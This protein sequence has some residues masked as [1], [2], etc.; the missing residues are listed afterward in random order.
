MK[1][2]LPTTDSQRK[3][4]PPP[5]HIVQSI[6]E[7]S[8]LVLSSSWPQ[9]RLHVFDSPDEKKEDFTQTV[10]ANVT[11]SPSENY[12][13]TYLKTKKETGKIVLYSVKLS[14]DDQPE[15]THQDGFDID[16]DLPPE[17]RGDNSLTVSDEGV[18]AL[19]R[20]VSTGMYAYNDF[21]V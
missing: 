1:R 3:D 15:V 12:V 19:V 17:M 14:E 7:P 5:H 6:T 8:A 13:V 20:V 2:S 18:V 21:G 10:V 9:D 16:F 4:R 11:I